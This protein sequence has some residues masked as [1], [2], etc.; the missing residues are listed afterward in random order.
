MTFR[1]LVKYNYG[2]QNAFY[3]FSHIINSLC[4]QLGGKFGWVTRFKAALKLG[5]MRNI[6]KNKS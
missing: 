3:S 4:Y 2:Q 6:F 5:L 1:G